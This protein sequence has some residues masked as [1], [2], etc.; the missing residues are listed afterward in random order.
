MLDNINL[1]SSNT[2][3]TYSKDPVPYFNIFDSFKYDESFDKLFIDFNKHIINKTQYF[4]LQTIYDIINTKSHYSYILI[5]KYFSKNSNANILSLLEQNTM[6]IGFF[7]NKIYSS[8]KL[9]NYIGIPI[10]N[11]YFYLIESIKKQKKCILDENC[12]LYPPHFKL[13]YEIDNDLDTTTTTFK[14]KQFVDKYCIFFDINN[15]NPILHHKINR[16]V[17]NFIN[18]QSI[19]NIEHN[20]INKIKQNKDDINNLHYILLEICKISDIHKL[21]HLY[22]DK[23][24][25]II[26]KFQNNIRNILGFYLCKYT[27]IPLYPK[28]K[29]IED[30]IEQKELYGILYNSHYICY[31]SGDKL[32]IEEFD[33]FMGSTLYRSTNLSIFE[34]DN[35]LI[36]HYLIHL[37]YL[38]IQKYKM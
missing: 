31:F 12:N 4:Y 13:K 2:Y 32:D 38:G 25:S 20:I 1:L 34:D 33:E 17:E 8:I 11:N 26:I 30:P 14:I 7:I 28:Y 16:I 23:I 37:I 19:I 27:Y 18:N 15:I 9:C 29:I 6:E 22:S 5:D 24:I 3:P 21:F 36:L 10:K 35:L